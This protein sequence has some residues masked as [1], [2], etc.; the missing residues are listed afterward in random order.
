VAVVRGGGIRLGLTERLALRDAA[1][2]TALLAVAVWAGSGRF[3]FFDPALAGYLGA[4]LVAAFGTTYR[5]SAFWRRPASA[6]YA[7]ALAHGL[8]APRQAWTVEPGIYI[9]PPLLARE[10]GRDDVD[11]DRLDELDG[12]GGL[13]LEQ[14]VLITDDGCELLTAAV[15]L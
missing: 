13:R 15:P 14:N 4:T 3:A 7:R 2:V 12:F 6:V 11:W 5:L 8:R 9:V 1:S 10:R